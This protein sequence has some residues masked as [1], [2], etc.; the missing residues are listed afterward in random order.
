MRILLLEDHKSTQKLIHSRLTKQGHDTDIADNGHQAFLLATANSYDAIISDIMVPHWDGFKFLKAIEVVCPQLP[1]IIITSSHDH[2]PTLKR[3]EKFS[4]IIDI[5]PKPFDF[6]YLFEILSELPSQSHASVSKMA[7]I[8]ATIGPASNSQEILGKMILAG[9]DVARLNFSHGNYQE[10]EETLDRL[11]QAEQHWG[12]PVAVMVDLSGPKIRTGKMMNDC[13]TL[14]TEQKIVIQ[15][16]PIIGTPNAISTISPEILPDLKKGE[17]IMLD[18]GLMELRV[19]ESGREQVTCEVVVGGKL[20]SNKGMNLPETTLSFASVTKKDW[21]DLDWAINHSTDYVALSFVRSA[22]EIIEIKNHIAKSEKP[23]LR[24]IAKIEKP[25][26]VK[27]IGEIIEVSD[28]IMIARGDMGVELPAARVPRIQQRIIKLC[29]E[30][31][32]P[33]ITATQMLDSMTENSRPTRAE[34]TDVSVAIKE[35]TDAVMLSQETAAGSN[36]VNVVRTM[37]SIICEEESHSKMSVDQYQQLVEETTAN[38]ALTAAASLNNTKATLLFD[39]NGTLYPVLSKW[40]R[41]VTSILVTTSLQVA[42][43]ASLYKNITPL[44]IPETMNH[45]ELVFEAI[46]LAKMEGYI[47]KDDIIAVV[48]GEYQSSSGIQQIGT[49][50]LIKV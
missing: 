29:W 44:I 12:R 30:S 26:A 39:S 5:L 3:L 4:N 18:D 45:T 49:L 2:L 20:R 1:V 28:A 16:E 43:H 50:Q 46:E 17:L 47:H 7:R 37:A 34:V 38:P 11:R 14:C 9:M 42:R 41:K 24:V 35:G 13:I 21:Q 36:P 31:N 27:N 33:V 40:N 23:E 32:T 10:H 48:E 19:V 6:N 8:V 15:A 25:E 22:Q